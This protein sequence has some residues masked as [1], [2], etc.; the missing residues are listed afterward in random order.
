M[1]IKRMLFLLSLFC[2]YYAQAD[3]QLYDMVV[4]GSGPAGCA[5]AL[6]GARAS[7]S[8]LVITG[9]TIGGQLIG[10]HEVENW[11]GIIKKSGAEIMEDLHAQVQSFGAAF[12]YDAVVDIDVS[13]QPFLLTTRENGIIHAR[14]VILATG[15]T[16]KLLNVPGEDLYWGN[17]VSSCAVCDCFLFKNKEVIVVGGGDS[18][19]EEALQLAGYATHVTLVVRGP[20]LRAAPH[21]QEKLKEYSDKISMRYNSV[22]TEIVGDDEQGVTGVMMRDVITGQESFFA[23]DGVFLAIG[24]TPNTQFFGQV[25]T[26]D[27]TGHVSLAGRSQAT[28]IPGVFVAGDVADNRFKQAAKAAGDGVQAA[29]EAIDFLRF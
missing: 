26:L 14:S 20:A 13:Q 4:V 7:M 25:I 24:H 16:P 18:A 28:N 29:L 5:A 15:S 19:I 10:S 27:A 2:S 23:T 12:L 8:T 1:K 3:D 9:D 21:G 22:I 11:P 6:Y 17:G